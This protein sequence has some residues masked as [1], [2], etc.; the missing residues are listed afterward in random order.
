MTERRAQLVT[1]AEVQ[2]ALR[3]A[4]DSDDRTPE[5]FAAWRTYQG[6]NREYQEQQMRGGQS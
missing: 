4:L 6:L 3:R 2:Q 1:Y 5:G